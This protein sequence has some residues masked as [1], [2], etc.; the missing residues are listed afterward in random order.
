[1]NAAQQ[2][3]ER[4]EGEGG[5]RVEVGGEGGSGCEGER[6]KKRDTFPYLYRAPRSPLPILAA[7]PDDDI[8]AG[9]VKAHLQA[10]QLVVVLQDLVVLLFHVARQPRLGALDLLLALLG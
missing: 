10:C 8:A 6:E 1:M 9:A 4:R 5:E 2:E 7:H 3:R